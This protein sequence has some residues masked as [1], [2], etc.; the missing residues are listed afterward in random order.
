M[1]PRLRRFLMNE[2]L[3]VFKFP[4]LQKFQGIFYLNVSVTVMSFCQKNSAFLHGRKSNIISLVTPLPYPNNGFLNSNNTRCFKFFSGAFSKLSSVYLQVDK[5]D[6]FTSAT[7][8][9]LIPYV[10]GFHFFT[11][12][13]NICREMQLT[14][15]LLLCLQII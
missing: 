5:A 3:Y 11:A 10:D 13:L 9:T 14:D 6:V 7:D 2:V 4:S 1:I 15:H 8:R 12:S